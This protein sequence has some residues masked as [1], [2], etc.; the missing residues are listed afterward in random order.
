MESL[1]SMLR[2]YH[3]GRLI[4]L[5]G[6]GGNRAR[7]RR[8]DMGE[9]AGKYA[10][11]TVITLDNPRYEDPEAINADIIRGL[12]VHRGRYQVIMDRAEA[13]RYLLDH[14]REGDIVALIGKGHEEYQEIQ[15]VKHF[16][17]EEQVVAD[18]LA[19]RSI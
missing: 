19:K 18:Y 3:P 7:Q 9:I 5:F 12:E 15:G 11:L 8:Y 17:S 16:F 1:L 10:D 13:I 2:G 6:G 14:C 4:C